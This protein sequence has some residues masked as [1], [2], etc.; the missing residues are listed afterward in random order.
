MCLCTYVLVYSYSICSIRSS[1]LVPRK[2]RIIVRVSF[3]MHSDP[4]RSAQTEQPAHRS[5]SLVRPAASARTLCAAAL[6]AVS[7]GGALEPRFV[8]GQPLLGAYAAL[9]ARQP[10]QD[11]PYRAAAFLVHHTG[12]PQTFHG[13]VCSPPLFSSFPFSVF[14]RFSRVGI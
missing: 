2:S 8:V 10:A 11:P 1:F 7:S 4:L 12:P 14:F 5:A 13:L 3:P 6:A 9:A